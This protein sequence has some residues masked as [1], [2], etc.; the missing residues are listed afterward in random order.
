MILPLKILKDI[1]LKRGKEAGQRDM[2]KSYI[3]PERRGEHFVKRNM[4][5]KFTYISIQVCASPPPSFPGKEEKITT[6]NKK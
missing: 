6:K 1:R 4:H 2:E 3:F 5:G